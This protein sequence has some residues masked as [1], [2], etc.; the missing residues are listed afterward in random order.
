M[1]VPADQDAVSSG[2]DT[3]LDQ[4]TAL[5]VVLVQ[6]PLLT[7]FLRAI[8]GSR[9]LAEDIFQDLVVLVMR[10]HAEIPN[11]AAVPGWTRRAGR[12]LALKALEK[13]ARERPVMDEELIGLLERTWV[14]DGEPAADPYLTALA[15]CRERLT[16]QARELL[17]LRYVQDLPGEQIALRLGRPLNTVYVTM[18]RLHRTL[19][20]CIRARLRGGHG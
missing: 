11:V 8:V 18:S 12:F 15:E 20:E 7:G 4:E 16:A 19:A 3:G 13:R 6:E 1:G 17:T 5:R 9:T 2:D 14:D 10:K